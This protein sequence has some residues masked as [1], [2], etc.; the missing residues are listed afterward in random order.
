MSQCDCGMYGGA[1]DRNGR[2]LPNHMCR[3]NQFDPPQ[4][5]ELNAAEIAAAEQLEREHRERVAEVQAT[6]AA[7]LA[8]VA[9]R[10]AEREAAEE[11][12]QERMRELQRQFNAERLERMRE[13]FTNKLI[14]GGEC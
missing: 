8:E 1:S 3:H 2:R 9:E 12:R 14:Y 10:E 5:V 13:Q 6:L 7:E 11:L 4:Y